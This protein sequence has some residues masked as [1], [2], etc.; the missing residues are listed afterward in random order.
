[1]PLLVWPECVA[2]LWLPKL[3]RCI[4]ATANTMNENSLNVVGGLWVTAAFLLRSRRE[5]GLL[6][7]FFALRTWLGYFGM[8]VKIKGDISFLTLYRGCS[9]VGVNTSSIGSPLACWMFGRYCCTGIPLLEQ[10]GGLHRL[11]D[12]LAEL[13]GVR[14]LMAAVASLSWVVELYDVICI[15]LH[16]E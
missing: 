8:F 16:T 7:F 9:G 12:F 3:K 6:S 15:L 4:E 5:I 11:S 14:N 10:D 13:T 1:M 2:K